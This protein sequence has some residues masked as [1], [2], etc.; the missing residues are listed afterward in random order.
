MNDDKLLKL[1][2]RFTKPADLRTLGITGLKMENYQV[3]NCI[4]QHKS[5]SEAAYQLLT[6]W[7]EENGEDDREAYQKI[8]D[9]LSEIGKA[10]F[11]K[12]LQ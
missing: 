9:V 6:E 3:N 2:K 1:S 8:W 4:D 11:R 7:K 10:G 5:T 12:A